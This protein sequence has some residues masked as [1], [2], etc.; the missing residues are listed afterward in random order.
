[1]REHYKNLKPEA[2]H[3]QAEMNPYR[4]KT[5]QKISCDSYFKNCEGL[6]KPI[7]V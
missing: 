6:L 2:V 1:L 5:G 3:I 7:R 4:Q